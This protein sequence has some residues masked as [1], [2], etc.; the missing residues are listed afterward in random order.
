MG[1]LISLALKGPGCQGLGWAEFCTSHQASETI[2]I[3]WG[4]S[5]WGAPFIY[6]QVSPLYAGFNG[7]QIYSRIGSTPHVLGHLSE[8]RV[9]QEGN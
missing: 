3:I 4:S 1:G 7:T 5:V 2:L 6:A 8:L 9:V